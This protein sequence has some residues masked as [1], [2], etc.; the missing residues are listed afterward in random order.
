MAYLLIQFQ[1]MHCYKDT[2]HS[3]AARGR[4]HRFYDWVISA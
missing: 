1:L 3:G 4:Y 2:L